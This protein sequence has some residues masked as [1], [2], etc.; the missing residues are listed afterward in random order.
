M[1]ILLEAV[2]STASGRLTLRGMCS[3]VLHP[4]C[5]ATPNSLRVPRVVIKAGTA[6]PVF[7]LQHSATTF[8]LRIMLQS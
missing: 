6:L 8:G 7:L 3:E 4:R 1:L 5:A 2:T